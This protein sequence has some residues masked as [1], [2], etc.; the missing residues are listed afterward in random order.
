MVSGGQSEV[1]RHE[2]SLNY[3]SPKYQRTVV[4][5]QVLVDVPVTER[6]GSCQAPSRLVI[7]IA[8]TIILS[9]IINIIIIN[10]N[11]TTI[12]IT[13]KSSRRNL[14]LKL[15]S[16]SC[17]AGR[18]LF[19]VPIYTRICSLSFRDSASLLTSRKGA[20]ADL[21]QSGPRGFKA[22]LAQIF[23]CC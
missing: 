8:V 5:R 15:F 1:P 19:H 3:V 2:V 22:H 20:R 16:K 4:V 12:S 9:N 11:N 18:A 6:T 17:L 21:F 10:T 13:I 7:T 23:F 14:A